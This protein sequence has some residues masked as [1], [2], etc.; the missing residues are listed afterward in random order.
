MNRTNL[1]PT[2]ATASPTT[3]TTPPNPTPPAE[4]TLFHYQFFKSCESFLNKLRRQHPD[5]FN[6]FSQITRDFHL[7][8]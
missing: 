8:K 3:K 7:K 2:P 6:L 5:L 4:Y 1:N